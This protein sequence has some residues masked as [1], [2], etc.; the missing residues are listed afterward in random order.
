MLRNYLKIAW[1]NI[2]GNPMFSAINIIGLAIGL[3][4][5]IIITIFV[6]YEMSYDKHWDNADRIYRVTRDFFGNDLKLA[7]VAPPIAPLMRQDF[8]EV[9][10]ITRILQT[11][12]VTLTRGDMR[13][14]E[15]QMVIADTNVF[16]FFNLEFVSGDPESA[17]NGPLDLVMTESAVERYFGDEDPI[18]QTLTVH[19]RASGPIPFKV[20]GVTRR[21]L[22]AGSPARGIGERDLNRDV[23]IPFTT[24]DTRYGEP[25]G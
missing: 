4:C 1:R 18:G 9:E 17:L 2:V 21:V 12:D 20:I 15:R 6:R 14:R 24:A 3:A 13:V 11:G 5:C 23:F 10:D 25:S 16:E 22:T 19:N 7:A 8:A